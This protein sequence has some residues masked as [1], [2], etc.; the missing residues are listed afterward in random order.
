MHQELVYSKSSMNLRYFE[1]NLKS[2]SIATVAVDHYIFDFKTKNQIEF[3]D[4]P[5]YLR[6][7]T[8]PM[9]Y[10]VIISMNAARIV[11][12]PAWVGIT[13]LI[14]SNHLRYFQLGKRSQGSSIASK[15]LWIIHC[16]RSSKPSTRNHW[17]SVQYFDVDH[18]YF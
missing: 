15:N 2:C 10:F 1:T 4:D 3:I 18:F 13:S 6:K 12:R 7:T 16:I 8:R 5:P 9:W 17:L 11:N 14:I